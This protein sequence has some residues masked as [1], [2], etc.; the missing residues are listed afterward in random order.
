MREIVSLVN[1][2][3]YTQ[4]PSLN[5]QG[6]DMNLQIAQAMGTDITYGWLVESAQENSGLKGGTSQA[7]ILGNRIIIGGDIIIGAGNTAIT[8]SDDLLAYLE[9]NTTP[10]QTVEFTVIR[11]GQQQTV[12][13]EIGNL[14]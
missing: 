10:G 5:A 12:T 7:T 13:V 4:H 1:T 8:N 11:S 2:G 3:S 9:R 14:T 6:T